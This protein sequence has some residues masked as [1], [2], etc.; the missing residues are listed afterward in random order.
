AHDYDDVGDGEGHVPE[1]LGHRPQSH[2]A[3][4]GQ[5]NKNNSTPITISGVTSGKSIR[6]LAGLAPQPVQ[7]ARPM[8]SATPRG[9]AISIV[10]AGS[11]RIWRRGPPKKGQ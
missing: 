11:W 3:E 1:D 10:T 2:E 8:A 6:K 9:V 7:R 5:K 4:R